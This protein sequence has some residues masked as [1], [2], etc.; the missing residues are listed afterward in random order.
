MD[1]SA[2]LQELSASPEYRG[3]IAA[4]LNLPP[5]EARFRELEHPLHPSVREALRRLGV[6]RLWE[7]QAR[8]VDLA[9]EGHNL[10]VLSA[11]ASGKTLCYLL[12]LMEYLAQRP[13]SRALLL[14]PTKA[15]AQDQ[16]RRLADFGAGDHFQADTYDGDTAAHRRRRIKR[17]AQVVLTNPDML[18]VGILPYHHTWADFFRNLKLV[19]LDEVHVYRGVFGSHTANVLRRLRRIAHHYGSDPQIICCSATIANPGELCQ[20]LTGVPVEVVDQDGSPQ[21][22]RTLVLWNPPP[23]NLRSGRRR[24]ANMEAAEWVARLMQAGVRSICFALARRQAEL[25]LQ[26]VRRV[27]AGSTLGDKIMAY[28]GGY[29]PAERRQI[30]KRLFDGEL[31]AVTSTTALEVGVDIGGL[32]AVI[33][34]GYPGTVA[35][36]WQQIGRAGRGKQDALAVLVA[37]PGGIHQYLLQ[38][39]EYLTSGA[40]RALIDP[41]NRYILAGHLLCASYELALREQETELFGPQMNDILAILAEHRYVTNRRGSWYWICPDLYPAAE[42]SIRSSSG[43]GYDIVLEQEGT[44]RLLGTVDDASAFLMVHEGAVYLHGGE[45]YLVHKLD[46]ARRVATVRAA[47]VNYYTVAMSISEVRVD[48]AEEQQALPGDTVCHYGSLAVKSAVIGYTR[49]RQGTDAEMGQ[50]PLSLPASAYETTGLWLRIGP[51]DVRML[52]EAGHDLMGSIHALEHALIALLPLFCMCDPHDV[53]G[54]SHSNHPDLGGPGIFLYDGHPGG[55]GICEAAYER[56][57]ELLAAAA[58]VIGACPCE[59]GCPSCVQAPDCGDGNRPLDKEGAGRLA[60]H[61]AGGNSN[62]QATES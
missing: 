61:W 11:T 10:V 44:T 16:L 20:A 34:A 9:L 2:L 17:E 4:V 15:L 52:Q 33:L 22:N 55:V 42:I 45:T 7:H 59:E 32:D 5:R 57:G 48:I 60:A 12:P 1:F 56:V 46:L 23:V 37:L 51:S 14:Y 28:R 19:V 26:H 8:A 36:T 13:A 50:F 3:R 30:E 40:E 35:S 6:Q 29:L 21:G 39:P 62:C 31:L 41:Q 27:L 25:I 47:K 24:S 43:A 58:Q 18:H 38:H 54:V 49:R 53:G